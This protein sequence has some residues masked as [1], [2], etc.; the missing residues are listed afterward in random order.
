MFWLPRS[1]PKSNNFLPS[2]YVACQGN[3]IVTSSQLG[4]RSIIAYTHES[5]RKALWEAL[6]FSITNISSFVPR[7]FGGLLSFIL[8]CLD[9]TGRGNH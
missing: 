3:E 1:G 7:Y 9:A 6:S 5:N 8:Y 2:H 4:K